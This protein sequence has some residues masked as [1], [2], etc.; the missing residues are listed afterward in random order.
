MTLFHGLS[1]FPVTPADEA[2][3][4]DT[5]RLQA[6]V[7]R[8]AAAG[9]ASIGVLGSTGGYPYFS[10]PERAR[11]LTAAVAAANS[12]P[13]LAGIGALRASDVLRHAQDA[14]AAGAAGLLLAPVSYLPLTDGEVLGLARDV[15]AA[16]SLPILIYNNPGT[17]HFTISEDLLLRLAEIPTVRAVKN[18]APPDGDFAAQ[19]ARLRPR[20]P[21]HFS[22]GYS[23]DA[24]IVGALAAG[25]DAWYSVIAGTFPEI[26]RAFWEARAD[27]GRLAAL[28]A[29]LG[30]LWDLFTAHGGIRVIHE[31][32]NLIGLGPVAL[33]R[34][35]LPLPAPVRDE[36]AAALAAAG[37]LTGEAA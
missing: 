22:L 20:L 13:V 8:L 31:A 14:E 23:G 17:T 15:A 34:P 3:R 2:G 10:S 18:P 21:E 11:A 6:L 32:V 5:D 35:L 16:S 12:A 1:A 19:I 30:P 25:A 26:C 7:S 4:V 37:L 33:P 24:T 28:D 27:P 9:V 36:I 29:R